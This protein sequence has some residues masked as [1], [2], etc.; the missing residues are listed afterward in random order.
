[1]HG[2]T[3][4]SAVH[5]VH[6]FRRFLERQHDTTLAAPLRQW[7]A[8]RSRDLAEASR[9]LARLGQGNES[10]GTEAELTSAAIDQRAED[11]TTTAGRV[12]HQV[13]SISIRVSARHTFA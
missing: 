2:T 3:K 8:S 5:G 11:P 10:E 1:M 13:E 4:R 9:L 12:D 7:I 6:L